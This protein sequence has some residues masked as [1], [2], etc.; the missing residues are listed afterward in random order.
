MIKG[1]WILAAGL[2]LVLLPV[3]AEEPAPEQQIYPYQCEKWQSR[4]QALQD[5]NDST[6]QELGRLL[7]EPE[8]QFCQ[9]E[10]VRVSEPD[11][12]SEPW[13]DFDLDFSSLAGILR[14]LAIAALIGLA[15]WL[16]W[17]WRPESF[18]SPSAEY[19]RR[20]VPTNQH[21]RLA[22]ETAPLPT[23][24]AQAAERAW[25]EGQHRLAMSLLYRGA[26]ARL[27]PEQDRSKART[28]REILADIRSRPH[29]KPLIAF[30]TTL[31]RL[32]QQTAWASQ[33]P[34][35]DR[36]I[37]LRQEWQDHFERRTGAAS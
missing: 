29:A 13:F 26:V 3:N 7:A 16:A 18:R 12:D 25:N 8:L 30:V 36:F 6:E 27:L 31:T 24:I 35:A 4:V 10:R 21:G 5:S 14:V 23:D 17:R 15:L 9:T 34:E 37:A 33:P 20:S 22:E 11:K 2:F 19:S 28:E 1:R 32:W